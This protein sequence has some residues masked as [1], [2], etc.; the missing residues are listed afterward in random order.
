MGAALGANAAGPQALRN[1]SPSGGV[2]PS[3]A[4]RAPPVTAT[5]PP[6]PRHRIPPTLLALAPWALT[7]ALATAWWAAR[8]KAPPPRN[9]LEPK[10]Q[11]GLSQQAVADPA[12]F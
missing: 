3:A 5:Q 10:P 8:R 2:S 11:P 6:Q 7:A 9:V 12:E 1:A 4:M